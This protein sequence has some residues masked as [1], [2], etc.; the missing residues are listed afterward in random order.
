MNLF[1][2]RAAFDYLILYRIQEWLNPGSL[3]RMERRLKQD[4]NQTYLLPPSQAI[5]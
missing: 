4:S 3:K 2:A 5:R 1:Y